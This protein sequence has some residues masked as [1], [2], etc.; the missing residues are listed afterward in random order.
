MTGDVSAARAALAAGAA[1]D[2]RNA[3]GISPL[4]VCAG[5]MGPPALVELLL[6]NGAA[7]DGADRQGWSPLTFVCS[8][9][10]LPLVELLLGAGAD[11]DGG[12]GAGAGGPGRCVVRRACRFL[13]V[14]VCAIGAT[15]CTVWHTTRESQPGGRLCRLGL[16]R[17]YAPLSLPPPPP[18]PSAAQGRLAAAHARCVPGPRARRGAAAGRR[19]RRGRLDRGARV[20]RAARTRGVR[21]VVSERP[22]CTVGRSSQRQRCHVQRATTPRAPPPRAHHVCR[23]SRRWRGRPLPAMTT[24]WRCCWAGGAPPQP[25]GEQPPPAGWRAGQP[26]CQTAPRL[27]ACI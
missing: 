21:T 6:A 11:V 4:L 19:R 14:A 25:R 27:V 1:V 7:A 18:T 9:G 12:A 2:H 22:A 3:N 23:A 17:A 26:H 13:V 16:S 5:G 20:A 10:Q 24:S 8:S 15:T